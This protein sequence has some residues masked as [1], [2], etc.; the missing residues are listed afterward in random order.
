MPAFEELDY[1]KTRLGELILRRREVLSLGG[2][3]VY[4]V[5]LG[6]AFLMSSLFTTVEIALADLGLAAH[7]HEGRKIDVVVG[8]LGLGY[9]AQAALKDDAVK[10]LIVIDALAEVIEWHE[11]GIV[12]LGNGLCADAR[13]RFVHAD[14][15][16]KA[17]DVAAGFDP[18]NPGHRF[19]VVL[20]DI[21]H[22]PSKLLD[23]SHGAFYESEGLAALAAQLRPGGV[24][25]MWSDDPPDEGFLE[26]LKTVFPKVAFHIVSFHNPLQDRACAST[27][28]VASKADLLT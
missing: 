9:T 22:T 19:D 21:D 8:G 14:F 11:R 23:A 17:R 13:C 28:Y 7:G 6:E 5:I 18:E 2:L 1:R 24:F 10:N 26:S 16:E 12:P 27:V 15:F 25:A 4:E 3:E 20:L